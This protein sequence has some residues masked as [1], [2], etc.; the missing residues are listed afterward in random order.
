MATRNDLLT[1]TCERRSKSITVGDDTYY[2]RSL[3][4]REWTDVGAILGFSQTP[5]VD[6]FEYKAALLVAMLTDEA[7]NVL[8]LP[9][10]AERLG[11]LPPIL[12][13]TLV[14]AAQEFLD[15]DLDSIAMAKKN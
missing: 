5:R 10:D 9:E 11:D 7:G 2:L 15:E 12:V 4:A 13:E 8:L 3:T 6:A 1:R 14:N